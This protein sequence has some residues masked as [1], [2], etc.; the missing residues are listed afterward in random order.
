MRRIITAIPIGLTVL[1][2]CST[3]PYGPAVPGYVDSAEVIQAEPLYTAVQVAVPVRECWIEQVAH[4]NP[5]RGAYAG[6]V[7]GGIIGGVV[8]HQLASGGA[9]TPMTV[10][11]ALVGA[12]LRR[13]LSAPSYGP[14]TIAN[15]RRCQTVSRYEQRQHL[16]GY[17]VDYR[18]E[19]QTF[20]TRT[21]GHPGRFI[22]VRVNVDPVDGT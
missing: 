20:S 6:P 22:R 21:R 14:P 15:V 5:G 17:R 16:V 2:A 3:V 1:T 19:G 7:A 13:G 9:R 12:S 10:A 18:Y 11:G 8:G 4:R